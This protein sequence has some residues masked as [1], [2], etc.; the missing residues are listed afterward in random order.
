MLTHRL[1]CVC[2]EGGK[3]RASAS[4]I[5]HLALTNEDLLACGAVH[6]AHHVTDLTGCGV[7]L[8]LLQPAAQVAA[9]GEGGSNRETHRDT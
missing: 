4:A 6:V 3:G 8:V 2:V 1:L 5:Q 7:R 9:G